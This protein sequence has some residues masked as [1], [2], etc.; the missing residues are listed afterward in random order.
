MP[1]RGTVLAWLLAL[2]PA[3]DPR[4]PDPAGSPADGTAALVARAD[5]GPP[6]A[7]AGQ[8]DHDEGD[9]ELGATSAEHEIGVVRPPVTRKV[10]P[11]VPRPDFPPP[12]AGQMVPVPGGVLLRGSAVDDNLRDQFAENDLVETVITPFEMDV[13]P[14][15]NEPWR[16]FTTGV[17]R[18]EAEALCAAQGKRLCTE[19]EWAW[20]CKGA[21][22][23]RYPAANVYH[24]SDYPLT[25]PVAP[26][27][28]A[29]VFAMGRLLEWTA[30]AWGADP[31]QVERAALRGFAEG[32]ATAGRVLGPENGRRCAKRWHRLPEAADPAVGFRCCRG[33]P[34]TG[35]CF[36][37]RPRPAHSV[38]TN[39]RPDRFAEVIRQ[40]PELTMIHDNPHMFSDVDIRAVM[41]RRGTDRQA[42]A[43]QG[44][45]FNWKPVRWIPRQGTE[46]WVAVGRSNRHSFVVALHEA[47]DNEVYV[48]GS[49]LILFEQAVPLTLGH[50]EG[51]RDEMYWAPCWGCRDGGTI[52]WDDELN[53]VVITHRW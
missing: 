44:I 2:A 6:G 41:A 29:G 17:T 26:A 10:W 13:L 37:E 50:R 31:D 3:C 27:S 25:D 19:V 11:A 45:H 40:V 15:P 7:D 43:R 18:A 38:Y 32:Q 20:A 28:P 33:T 36:I 4:A 16:A 35:T 39:M 1:S 9:V 8:A 53:E 24:P 12:G 34:N 21:D 47:V 42:L 52:A 30:S 49:A 51:H 48:H 14:H 22:N 46:L 5:G 23:R